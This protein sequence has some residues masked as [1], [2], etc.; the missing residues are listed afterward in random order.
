MDLLW[1]PKCFWRTF[2]FFCCCY[3]CHWFNSLSR[4][5]LKG[6]KGTDPLNCSLF[7]GPSINFTTY[8]EIWTP[9]IIDQYLKAESQSIKYILIVRIWKT[10]RQGIEENYL[11][12]IIGK[13]RGVSVRIAFTDSIARDTGSHFS[14][15]SHDCLTT[16]PFLPS[17]IFRYQTFLSVL[18]SFKFNWHGITFPR[19]LPACLWAPPFCGIFSSTLCSLYFPICF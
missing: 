4:A 18:V 12:C 15:I 9:L 11:E 8:S 6:D 10:E 16:S 14:E 13:K 3:C 7:K 1:F 2:S 19:K 17:L 5:A